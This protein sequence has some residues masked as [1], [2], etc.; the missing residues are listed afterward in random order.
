M[1]RCDAEAQQKRKHQNKLI[2]LPQVKKGFEPLTT[3]CGHLASSDHDIVLR[4][5]YRKNIVSADATLSSSTPSSH[6]DLAFASGAMEF[7]DPTMM[8]DENG[9]VAE[10]GE[11]GNGYN[12]TLL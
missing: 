8:E 7:V 1:S 10:D 11:Y 3:T 12:G 5:V 6:H 9:L 4:P 2:R